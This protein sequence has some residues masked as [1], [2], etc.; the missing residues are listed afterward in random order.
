MTDLADH[1]PA[2]PGIPQLAA[3]EPWLVIG[4]VEFHSR[5][6]VGIEQYTSVDL[7]ADVLAAGGCDVF[8]TT[9]DLS[10]ERPSLMLS[11]LDQVMGLDNFI[12]I[13]TTSFARSMDEALATARVLRSTFG[14]TIMKLDVRPTDNLPD[15]AQTVQAARKLVE[16]GF[17]VLPFIT[18]D[19][20]TA[21]ALE[22][23]GCSAL[24]LMASPVASYRGVDD[25]PGMH[26]A[27]KSVSIPTIVE[28]GIGSPTHVMSGV[29]L[30][31]DAVLVNTA[32]AQAADP[33]R[34]AAAMRHAVLSARY[35]LDSASLVTAGSV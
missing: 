30:G 17:A 34:M 24:R 15:N 33:P 3:P 26:S 9:F 23:A 2:V 7:V 28:G 31:A 11:E 22:D 16:D 10:H 32:V 13:G 14:I 18:P 4:D 8:I 35:A 1:A 6:I 29:G 20:D 5:L 21:R 27:I 25:V 12:W 19:A